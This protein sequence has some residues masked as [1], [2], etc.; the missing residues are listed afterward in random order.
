MSNINFIFDTNLTKDHYQ[1]DLL[2]GRVYLAILEFEKVLYKIMD[3][4]LVF[5]FVGQDG[6]VLFANEWFLRALYKEVGVGRKPMK[7]PNEILNEILEKTSNKKT[8]IP[9]PTL[10]ALKEKNKNT[11]SYFQATIERFDFIQKMVQHS[12]ALL[13]RKFGNKIKSTTVKQSYLYYIKNKKYYFYNNSEDPFQY[14]DPQTIQTII[15]HIE[16]LK[17][18]KELEKYNNKT[19]PKK[20][21]R[22]HISEGYARFLIT[23]EGDFSSNDKE[24]QIQKIM[25]Y[26]RNDNVSQLFGGDIQKVGGDIQKEIQTQANHHYLQFSVKSYDYSLASYK[27]FIV[28]AERIVAQGIKISLSDFKDTIT[29]GHGGKINLT[30]AIEKMVQTNIESNLLPNSSKIPNSSKE[31]LIKQ[32]I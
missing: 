2:R 14:P 6:S 7:T 29:E 25:S 22:G 12:K 5:T 11:K 20:I 19:L 31:K 26:I 17:T 3:W 32:K 10:D 15:T 4:K 21:N 8:G 13:K 18:V 28:F 23:D 30:N 16:Y 9:T 27:S 1:E 24:Q